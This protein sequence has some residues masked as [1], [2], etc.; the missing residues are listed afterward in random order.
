MIMEGLLVTTVLSVHTGSEL[1]LHAMDGCHNYQ[2]LI[3]MV[4]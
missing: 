2:K 3:A 4:C 1:L